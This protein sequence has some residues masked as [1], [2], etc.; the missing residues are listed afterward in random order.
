MSLDFSASRTMSYINVFSFETAL[1]PMLLI[2]TENGPRHNQASTC[3][4]LTVF[5]IFVL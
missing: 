5:I 3:S 1:T 4:V 2:A